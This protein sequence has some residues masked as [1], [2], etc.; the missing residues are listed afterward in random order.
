MLIY[1]AEQFKVKGL[2][3]AMPARWSWN[4]N[5]WPY[6][7]KVNILTTA[8]NLFNLDPISQGQ[9][10]LKYTQDPQYYEPHSKTR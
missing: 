4:W 2:A 7:Q 1:T 3:Q 5:S 10:I 9:I 6:E 8:T